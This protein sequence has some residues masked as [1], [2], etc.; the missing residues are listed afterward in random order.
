MRCILHI[1]TEKTGSTAIQ[2]FLYHN[3][4]ELR[5]LRLHVCTSAGRANNRAL[6]AAFMAEKR[7]DDFLLTMN[8][9]SASDRRAWKSEFLQAFS[10]EVE[11][12]RENADTFVISSEHFHSRLFSREEVSELHSFLAPLFDSISVICYLRRQDQLALSRYSEALRAGHVP[13]SPLPKDMAKKKHRLLP[14]F[15]LLALLER[16]A[17]VF[18]QDNIEPHIYSKKSLLD[19]DIVTDFLAAVGIEF[20]HTAQITQEK[21]NIALSAEAQA[22]LL[23]VNKNLG[24]GDMDSTAR[25]R[26]KL[27]QYLQENAPG[28]SHQPSAS[29]AREFYQCFEAANDV[30]AR[31][32]FNRESLFETDFSEY[33]EKAQDV[34]TEKVVD[35]LA[36][37]MVQQAK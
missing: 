37:F 8:H 11:E 26:N 15:D 7:T 36:G 28:K 12:A 18:G 31:R 9:Q 22:I 33:P 6:P 14:Y 16:W 3:R 32:W 17:D 20:P 5:D 4:I 25:I 24:Q 1:G 10:E 19:G 35:I 13:P 2:E 34:S 23:G 21:A 27:V 29:Q 30:I